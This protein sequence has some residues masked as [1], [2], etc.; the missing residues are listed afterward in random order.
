MPLPEREDGGLSQEHHGGGGENRASVGC[1]L[2]TQ[3]IGP[4]ELGKGCGKPNRF[5]AVMP[6]HPDHGYPEG[7]I[8]VLAPSLWT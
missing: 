2:E 7:R 8:Y 5:F 4:D 6:P 1:V 3:I